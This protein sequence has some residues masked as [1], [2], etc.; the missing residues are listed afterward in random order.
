MVR[1][2]AHPVYINFYSSNYFGSKHTETDSQTDRLYCF[3][4]F[5]LRLLLLLRL[6]HAATE[7]TV[8][9]LYL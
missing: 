8:E 9:M 6:I 4:I 3:F 2:L 7:T 1:F 5:L